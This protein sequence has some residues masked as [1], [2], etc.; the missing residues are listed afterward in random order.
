MRL[1]C[2]TVERNRDTLYMGI[3]DSFPEEINKVIESMIGVTKQNIL[4]F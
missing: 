4:F 3:N 2:R 1:F